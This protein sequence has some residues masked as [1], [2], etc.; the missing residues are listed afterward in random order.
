MSSTKEQC[1]GD[2]SAERRPSP[3]RHRVRR[4]EWVLACLA[5]LRSLCWY[6]PVQCTAQLAGLTYT[7]CTGCRWDPF[8]N[9]AF[10]RAT[11]I[12]QIGHKTYSTLCYCVWVPV[13]LSKVIVGGRLVLVTTAAGLAPFAAS[14]AV[15][16]LISCN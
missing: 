3:D 16:F 1:A 4:V 13:R 10:L 6:G 9:G 5:C 2:R 11:P 7:F 15:H 8:A 14:P 12:I